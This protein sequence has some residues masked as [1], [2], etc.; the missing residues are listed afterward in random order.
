MTGSTVLWVGLRTPRADALRLLGAAGYRIQVAGS[1][2]EAIP[3]LQGAPPDVVILALGEHDPDPAG[4]VRQ[5]LSNAPSC[6]V[7]ALVSADEDIAA[8]LAAGAHDA[9]PLDTGDTLPLR[10]MIWARAATRGRQQTL[11]VRELA[12]KVRSLEDRLNETQRECDQLK[13]LAHRDEL[14]GLGNRRSFRAHLEQAIEFSRRYGGPISIL[15]ADLDGMK[16]LNDQCGHPAGDSALKR[17]AEIFRAS[18]RGSDH[19][20]RLGGDEFAVCMPATS[21]IAA[22]RV[23]ERMRCRIEALLLPNGFGL[24]AS[25]GVATLGNPRGVGFAADEL[26]ARAD[27]A[28]YAAKRAGRNRVEVDA[29]SLNPD[30]ADSNQGA[31]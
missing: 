13:D 9:L 26:F 25:F 15:V 6:Y 22:A 24:S 21:A 8:A 18:I 3:L 4:D 30:A 2:H 10:I 31:A 19:A 28:C 16:L 5:I 17:I 1:V 11:V 27:A 12:Q 14:T 23:A 20:A 29:H 7:V